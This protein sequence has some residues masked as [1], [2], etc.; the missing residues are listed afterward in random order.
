MSAETQKEAGPGPMDPRLVIIG[1]APS[2][3]S[4]FF[5]DLL[6]SLPQAA[7]G[8]EIGIFGNKR[9]YDFDRYRRDIAQNGRT[10][11]IYQTRVGTYFTEL[12]KYGLDEERYAA[13]VRDAAD[14]RQFAG[15]F[16]RHFAALRG[17]GDAQ[18]L[19]EKSP[20]NI[21][22]IGEFLE[23]F[24]DSF[25]VHIVRNPLYVYASLVRRGYSQYIAL[26]TWLIDVAQ[27]LPFKDHERVLSVRYEDLVED[28]YGITARIMG[29][30]GIEGATASA[31]E[32]GYA[33]NPYRAIYE[34]RIKS[35]TVQASNQVQDANKKQLAPETLAGFAPNASLRINPAY[36]ELFGI[37]APTYPEAIAHFGYDE[38]VG[39]LLQGHGPTG[40]GD[41]RN[42]ADWRHLIRRWHYDR[43]SG[44]ASLADLKTY[45]AP[46][47]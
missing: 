31:V 17:K 18:I 16:G 20:V 11:A 40:G 26:A 23:A 44:D 41:A 1:N 36:A 29:Q 28:P 46:V 15:L 8:V 25:F 4:T 14:A 9:F 13:M 22:C 39:R 37:A 12:F 42:W 30:V 33:E 21:C 6:D 19:F 35:W 2:S 3:G 32:A 47:V 27:Y 45:L 34:E 38:T 5:A 43:R 7:C 10:P 24:P